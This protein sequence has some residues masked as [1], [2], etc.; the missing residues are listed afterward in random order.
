MQTTL[1][2]GLTRFSEGF[3]VTAMVRMMHSMVRINVLTRTS[4]DPAVYGM[5][6]PQVDQMPAGLFLTYLTA[7]KTVKRGG[8]E[9]GAV[10]HARAEFARYRCF[11]LGLP[12]E[13]LPATPDKGLSMFSMR[14]RPL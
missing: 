12:E 10:E 9:F 6:I 3:K 1:P 5:P 2:G 4:W 13:L 7:K 11:L 14:D 8:T